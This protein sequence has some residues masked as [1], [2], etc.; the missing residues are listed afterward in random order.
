M[1]YKHFPQFETPVPSEIRSGNIRRESC[2]LVQT[3]ND[4]CFTS[5]ELEATFKTPKG[6]I[7]NTGDGE[8]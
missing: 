4:P 2:R 7:G 6:H 3:Y 8:K 5:S 1:N